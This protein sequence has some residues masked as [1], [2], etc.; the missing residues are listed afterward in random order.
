[1]ARYQVQFRAF[2]TGEWYTKTDTD[3]KPA[4]FSVARIGNYGRACRLIDT[5]TGQILYET[6]EDPDFAAVNGNTDKF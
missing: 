5:E 2:K 6:S 4:A 3:S 1:M